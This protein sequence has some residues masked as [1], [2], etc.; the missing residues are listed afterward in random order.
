MEIKLS[1]YLSHTI[2]YRKLYSIIQQLQSH[3]LVQDVHVCRIGWSFPSPWRADYDG[4]CNTD[5]AHGLHSL[6]GWW[7][8]LHERIWN[9]LYDKMS[10]Q[11]PPERCTKL[12]TRNYKNSSLF[13]FFHN[14]KHSL[15]R[16]ENLRKQTHR[17]EISH[18][19]IG[20]LMENYA[21]QRCLFV[22]TFWDKIEKYMTCVQAQNLKFL[23]ILGSIALYFH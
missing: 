6:R 5:D 16:F 11:L 8:S 22:K 20:A 4:A 17:V 15:L 1:E 2:V 13:F 10:H 12:G 18:T 23:D 21:M 14:I 19:W 3:P 7:H 9:K